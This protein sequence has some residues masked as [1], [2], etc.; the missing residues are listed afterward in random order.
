MRIAPR[1]ELTE[2]QKATLER[3]ARGKRTP[4][5]LIMR[6]KIVLLAAQGSENRAVAK[7]LGVTRESV[8]RW[9]LRF[10]KLGLAGIEKDAPRG[11]RKPLVRRRVEARSEERRVGKECA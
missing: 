8:G 7:E 11:G 10:V 3:W 4:A 9:R 2:E 5:R 1:V 6:A